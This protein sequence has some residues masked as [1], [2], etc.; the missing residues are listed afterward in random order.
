MAA[1]P[2]SQPMTINC[3]SSVILFVSDPC[4]S[5][6]C[7]NGACS[8]SD[9]GTPD[10]ICNTDFYGLHCDISSKLQVKRGDNCV[11]KRRLGFWKCWED[12]LGPMLKRTSVQC[13]VGEKYENFWMPVVASVRGISWWGTNRAAVLSPHPPPQGASSK[14]VL[15]NFDKVTY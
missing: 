15:D 2:V 13:G 3:S 10:C 12:L 5:Y 14:L 6:P 7:N 4:L 9:S 1:F 11:W 8:V